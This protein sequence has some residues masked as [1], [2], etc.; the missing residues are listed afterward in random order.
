MNKYTIEEKY[1]W[2]LSQINILDVDLWEK[3]AILQMSVYFQ[4]YAD[5]NTVSVEDAI[6][7]AMKDWYRLQDSIRFANRQTDSDHVVHSL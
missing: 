2:L 4:F 3:D 7:L 6:E 5:M 1:D